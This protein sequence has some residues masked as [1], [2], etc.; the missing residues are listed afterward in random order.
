MTQQQPPR[1]SPDTGLSTIQ[2]MVA[3]TVEY[4][5]QHGGPTVARDEVRAMAPTLSFMDDWPQAYRWAMERI[6]QAEKAEQQA[7]EMHEQ[8]KLSDLLTSMMAA[9]HEQALP[10]ASSSASKAADLTDSH[11]CHCL[12]RLMAEEWRPGKMLFCQQSHWQAVFRIL[13]DFGKFADD[14]FDGFDSWVLR[15]VPPQLRRLYSKQ[16]VKNI[17]QTLFNKPFDKWAYDPELMKKR[18]PYDRMEQ[19]ARRFKELLEGN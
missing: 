19:I 13:S 6:S 7:T 18:V 10:P 14:D 2:K 11:V 5:L 3:E 4:Y 1:A 12:E 15:V 8:H 17:S 9:V 16:S